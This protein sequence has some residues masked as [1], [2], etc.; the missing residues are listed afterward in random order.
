M[1]T[2]VYDR[3]RSRP[4]TYRRK[5]VAERFWPKVDR[6]G[7]PDACWPFTGCIIKPYGHGQFDKTTAHRIAF[8]LT[9]GR[10]P[11]P[12]GCH[13]CDNPPCCNPA[14]LFEG[15]A[16]DNI[17]DMIA[18]GRMVSAEA[19]SAALRGRMPSGDA[20]HSRARP[21]TMARGERNGSAVLDADRVRAIRVDLLGLSSRAVARKF[22]VSR[23]TVADILHRVTWR[24]VA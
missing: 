22:G 20:H 15:T 17:D 9:H 23:S 18:K 6:S 4:R 21:E 16:Q 11:A 7:G 14:H 8:F 19:R 3:S 13:S 24:H 2:G 12:Y 10:L 5:S 1:P